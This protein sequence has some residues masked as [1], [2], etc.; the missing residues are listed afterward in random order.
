MPEMGRVDDPWAWDIFPDV[1]SLDI[2]LGGG[3]QLYI[4][5]PVSPQP[6][7]PC[8]YLL[9]RVSSLVWGS[10]FPTIYAFF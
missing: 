4:V 8:P 9:K 3:I 2:C 7:V 5:L 6:V 1:N 10:P